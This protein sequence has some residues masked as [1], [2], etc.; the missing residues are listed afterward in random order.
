MKKLFGLMLVLTIVLSMSIVAYAEECAPTDLIYD[1][2]ITIPV[3]RNQTMSLDVPLGDGNVATLSVK[4]VNGMVY[5]DAHGKYHNTNNGNTVSSY[6][7]YVSFTVEDSR[8]SIVSGDQFTAYHNASTSG[9]T[10]N[11]EKSIIG[12]GTSTCTAKTEYT[13][14]NSPDTE[15]TIKLVINDQGSSTVHFNGN[16]SQH[17]YNFDL[18]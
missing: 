11:Y 16:F 6:G 9:Y 3:E 1:E 18:D 14:S 15:I 7:M 10:A 17:N 8:I 5:A 4:E 13:L 2:E 12:E